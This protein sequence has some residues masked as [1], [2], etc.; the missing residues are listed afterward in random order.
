[1]TSRPRMSVMVRWLLRYIFSKFQN[2][3]HHLSIEFA[4]GSKWQNYRNG[5][6]EILIRFKTAHAEWY[7]LVFF[8]EG[9][10]EKYIDGE[11]DLIGQNP[12]SLLFAM[13]E[14]AHV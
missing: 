13:A 11:I 10:F 4:D 2:D 5:E 3:L 1:M 12:A 7:S 8:Y 6:P 14:G 9:F